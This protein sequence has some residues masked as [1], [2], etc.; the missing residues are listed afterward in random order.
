M[1]TKR[2]RDAYR[3]TNQR[4]KVRFSHSGDFKICKS[5]K[6]SIL[7]KI[8]IKRHLLYYMKERESENG[9]YILYLAEDSCKKKSVINQAFCLINGNY[10]ERCF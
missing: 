2:E 1:H 8:T 10:A 5:F 6:I 4:I 9:I 7:K 3:H